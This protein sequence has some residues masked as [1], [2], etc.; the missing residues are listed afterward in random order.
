MGFARRVFAATA[1][2]A[3]GVGAIVT[4]MLPRL[5]SASPAGTVGSL[6]GVAAGGYMLLWESDAALARDLDAV[7]A[8][9]AQWVRFDFDWQSAQPEPGRFN[10]G[11]IDRVVAGA[12]AR[13]L[14]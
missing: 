2:L 10:W 7:V 11:P 8:T 3:I 6:G 1:L 5:A 9:G 4:P 12:R 13:G 14:Q